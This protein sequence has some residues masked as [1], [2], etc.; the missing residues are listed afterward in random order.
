[1]TSELDPNYFQ[2]GAKTQ[3]TLYSWIWLLRFSL[4]VYRIQEG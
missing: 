4:M 3:D 1:M 2:D